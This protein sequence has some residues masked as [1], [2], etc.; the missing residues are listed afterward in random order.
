MRFIVYLSSC[1]G[2]ITRATQSRVCNTR[3][4]TAGSDQSEPELEGD[5]KPHNAAVNE[6]QLMLFLRLYKYK[7]NVNENMLHGHEGTWKYALLYMLFFL[8]PPRLLMV[9][10]SQKATRCCIKMAAS[11]RHV[12]Q[13]FKRNGRLLTFNLEPSLS[14]RYENIC[15][16]VLHHR[17][18]RSE[19][20][21]VDVQL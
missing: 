9:P 11:G 14:R 4:E 10:S 13:Y 18:F 8:L 5:S 17:W 21:D 6:T 16:Y 15:S 20:G 7:S 1:R 2:I 19:V 12:G 3:G